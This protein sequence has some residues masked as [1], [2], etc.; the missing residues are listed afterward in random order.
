M[1][2]IEPY[3]VW[4]AKEEHKRKRRKEKH[5]RSGHS[6]ESRASNLRAIG[7]S[8]Y[9]DYLKSSLWAKIRMR[10]F[11]RKGWHCWLCAKDANAIHHNRYRVCDLLGWTYANLFPICD[12][13]HKGI[14]FGKKGKKLDPNAAKSNFVQRER[15]KDNHLRWLLLEIDAD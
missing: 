15:A 7:F 10:V 6:Y 4:K 9:A 2:A 14:E 12:D 5:L 3:E 8:S 13:C 11:A 1:K